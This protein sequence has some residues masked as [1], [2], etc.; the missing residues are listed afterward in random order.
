[1][2]FKILE[3][4]ET[5]G[6]KFGALVERDFSFQD[7]LYKSLFQFVE[8]VLGMLGGLNRAFQGRYLMIWEAWCIL[9]LLKQFSSV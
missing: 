5:R 3:L 2:L 1:M 7:D 6:K 8:F 9:N 4:V